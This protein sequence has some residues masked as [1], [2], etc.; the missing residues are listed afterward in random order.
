[1]GTLCG[2]AF[3]VLCGVGQGSVVVQR[4][5]GFPISACIIVRDCSGAV[6]FACVGTFTF[7]SADCKQG[8]PEY[9]T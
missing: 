3:E 9:A 1:M 5:S 6:A 2:E 7:Q 8:T 4:V